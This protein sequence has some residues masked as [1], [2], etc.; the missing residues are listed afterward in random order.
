MRIGLTGPGKDAVAQMLSEIMGLPTVAFATPLHEASRY[1]WGEGCL[2]RDQKDEQQIFGANTF[3]WF[4]SWHIKR[5]TEWNSAYGF[6]NEETMPKL[7]LICSVF[8]QGNRL[9]DTISPREFMQQYG[10]GFW[11][12]VY[13]ELFVNLVRDSHESCI[14]TDVR[15]DNEAALCD[16]LIVVNGAEPVSDAFAISAQGIVV[17]NNGTLED[18]RKKVLTL[19]VTGKIDVST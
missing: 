9:R 16:R 14:I 3:E 12:E 13:P 18:L 19:A 11:R 2:E 10:V 5:L 1:I 17:E 8:T 7:G 6:V 15:F 4:N